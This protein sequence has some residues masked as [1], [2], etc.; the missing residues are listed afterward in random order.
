MGGAD[1]SFRGTLGCDV[2]VSYLDSGLGEVDPAG[3]VL[4]DKGIGVVCPLKHSLQ[5]LE[6]AAVE[7]GPV[8]AL[9]PLLL[10]LRVHLF[11]YRE[12]KKIYL[13]E[14]KWEC[15]SPT[16]AHVFNYRLFSLPE[17]HKQSQ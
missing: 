15:R 5:S 11:I 9:L 8:P 14:V 7:G 17:E 3:E 2:S 10:L 4:S 6:L 1:L 16:G 12:K 13:H